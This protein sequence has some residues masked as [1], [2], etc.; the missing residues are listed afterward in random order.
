MCA[1]NVQMIE[2]SNDIEPHLAPV[3]LRIMRLATLAM[4]AHV[5]CDNSVILGQIGEN[6]WHIPD[7]NGVIEPVDKDD[8]FAEP[9]ST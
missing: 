4:A 6:P 8:C 7:L 2:Q 9:W 5:E 3:L 1:A